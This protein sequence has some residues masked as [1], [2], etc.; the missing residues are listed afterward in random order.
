MP[1][2]IWRLSTRQCHRGSELPQVGPES[3]RS[4]AVETVALSHGSSLADTSP[5]RRRSA[6]RAL[7]LALAAPVLLTGCQLPSFGAYQGVSKAGNDTFKLWQGFSIAAVVIGGGTFLLILWAAMRYRAKGDKIP[8]QTQYNIPLEIVYTIL[9]ILVVIGLFAATVVVENEVVANPTPQA[10]INVSAFQWGWKFTYPHHKAVIV[11]QTTQ[12]PVMVMPADEDVRI[13]LRSLDVLHGFYV[14]KFNFS[15]YAQPGLLNTFTFK[16]TKTGLYDAQCSQLCGLYH[17]LM[18]FKVRV[19]P[20]DEFNAWLARED[21][22][23]ST[24]TAAAAD[25]A[26]AAALN[27]NIPTIP[28]TSHGAN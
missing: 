21:A 16:V 13:N 20:R 22:K 26:V 14:P 18:Y 3:L 12:S 1:I 23:T 10:T 6:R 9:P 8:K 2:G 27:P 17:S 5:K 24:A 15:R 11:G 19:L 4:D 25:G 7:L 28:A